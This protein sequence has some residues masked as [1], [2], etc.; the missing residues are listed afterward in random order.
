[1]CHCRPKHLQ[2]TL[3]FAGLMALLACATPGFAQ[4]YSAEAVGSDSGVATYEMENFSGS[5]ALNGTYFNIYHQSNSGVG[6]TN[7]FTQFGAFAPYWLSPDSFIAPNARMILTDNAAAGF[8][9]GLVGRWYNP[10][11]DRILGAY[12]YYDYDQS[13]Y[14]H[15]YDQLTFGVE[16]LGRI[17]DAR[18]NAYVP[19]NNQTNFDK[20]LALS[21]NMV[22]FGNRLGFVGTQLSERAMAGGDAELGFPLAP[23]M[24]WLRGYAGG[25]VYSK[26]SDTLVGGVRGRVEGWITQN[27]SLQMMVTSDSVFGTNVNF[28][29]DYRFPGY[30]PLRFFPNWTVRERM[31]N[32]V[33]RNWR[34]AVEE[35]G[36]NVNIAANNPRDNQP[37]FVVWVDPDNANPGSGSGTY[38]DPYGRLP[39]NVPNETDMVMVTRGD[40]TALTPSL[41]SINLPDYARLLGE[42]HAHVVDAWANFGPY[43]M[44]VN[45]ALLPDD[46]FRNTGLY[47]FLSNPA[48]NIVNVGN[49]NEVAALVLM[50]ATGA[51]IAGQHPNGFNFHNL[52]ISGNLG[53]GIILAD[54]QGTGN[55]SADGQIINGG[56]IY[57][58]NRNL[59]PG[60][61]NPL[62]LGNNGPVGGINI[63]TGPAGAGP[64]ELFISN[65]SMN[66]APG[67]QG[68]GIRVA[69]NDADLALVMEDVSTSGGNVVAGISIEQGLGRIDALLGNEDSLLPSIVSSNNLGAGIRLLTGFDNPMN[70][71]GT[72]I[73]ANLNVGDNLQIAALGTADFTGNFNNSRFNHSVLGSGIAL[74][75]ASGNKT[76]GLE[77]V[78]AIGNAARGVHLH[79]LGGNLTLAALDLNA[80]LNVGTNLNIDLLNTTFNGV[81]TSNPVLPLSHFDNSIT[82]AGI[83]L[84]AVNSTSYL[85]LSGL[86]ANVNPLG[87]VNLTAIGGS[88][89]FV[90]SDLTASGNIATNLSINLTGANFEGLITSD[91]ANA[92][93][94]T[95]DNS[96]LG[97]GIALTAIGG[98]ATLQMRDVR[99]NSNTVDGLVI[100]ALAG[101]QIG[102]SANAVWDGVIVQDSQF[103]GN[104]GMG[105]NQTAAGGSY[106]EVFVD[107]T[108]VSGNGFHGSRFQVLGGSRFVAL[109]DEVT[110]DANGQNPLALELP[111]IGGR[112]RGML[113]IVDGVGSVA[114]VAVQNSS[115]FGSTDDGVY[116]TTNNGAVANLRLTS[117]DIINS[118]VL[119]PGASGVEVNALAGLG[120]PS[121]INLTMDGT[122]TL[123][124]NAPVGPAFFGLSVNA[125]GPGT[126][127]NVNADGTS[128]DNTVSHAVQ[129]LASLGATVNFEFAN[130][131]AT[132]GGGDGLNA[133]TTAGS[134]FN[135]C[136]EDVHFDDFAGVG[137]RIVTT[138]PLAVTNMHVEDSSA[139][140]NAQGGLFAQA[141]L[142]GEL[143][144]RSVGSSFDNNG[145]VGP[146]PVDGVY[147]NAAGAGSIARLLFNTSSADG[148][149]RNGFNFESQF[150]AYMTARIDSISA[151]DN[152]NYGVRLDVLGLPNDNTFGILIPEG[153]NTV[154]G[155]GTGAYQINYNG[156]SVAQVALTGSFVG[157]PTNGV[158]V[159]IANVTDA[160]VS[161]IG[162]GNDNINNNAGDGININISNA[163]QAGVFITG[164]RAISNNQ[165]DGIHIDLDNIATAAAVQITGPTSVFVNDDNGVAIELTDVVLG[166]VTSPAGLNPLSVLT[167][168]DNRIFN[169]CLPQPVDVNFNFAAITPT[170]N[171]ILVD[172]LH[173]RQ[174]PQGGAGQ[175]GIFI[176]GNHVTGSGQ[177]ILT[178]NRIDQTDNGINASFGAVGGASSFGGIGIG[179]TVINSS[180][181]TGINIELDASGAPIV[182]G[183][184]NVNTTNG[185]GVNIALN[186]VIG[187]NDIVV[188]NTNVA[189]S[190][191]RG[192]S[193]EGNGAIGDV[194]LLDV[195]ARNSTAG[196][197]L[198]IVLTNSNVGAVTVDGLG[199]SQVLNSSNNGIL[200]DL[201]D[202]A[203]SGDVLLTR[204][205]VNLS[206]ANGIRLNLDGVTGAPDVSV[207]NSTINNSTLL[208]INYTSVGATLGTVTF[209]PL[210]I[211]N[212]GSTGLSVNLTNAQLDALIM[213][214]ITVTNS[215]NDGIN[216]LLNGT[217]GTPDIT[218]TN[219]TTTNSGNRGVRVVGL[220]SGTNPL[221]LGDVT[222]TNVTA[223]NSGLGEGVVVDFA[224]DAV[225]N[226]TVGAIRLTDVSSFTSGL[227]GI[228]VGLNTMSVGSPILVDGNG[229]AQ[230]NDAGG[231]GIEVRLANVTGAPDV[232]VIDYLSVDGNG[233]RGIAVLSNGSA[234]GDVTVSD[235]IVTNTLGA[236][237]VFID[238]TN[239]AVA[240]MTADGNNISDSAGTGLDVILNGVTGAPDVNVTNS[241]V[242]NSGNR[243]ISIVGTSATLGDVNLSDNTV[244]DSLGGQGELIDLTNSVVASVTADTNTITDSAGRGLDVILNGVT[245][246]P[247]I[248]ITNATVTNSGG[249]GVSVSG[250]GSGANPMALGDV[251]LT[252]VSS[253]TT[254]AG[255]GVAVVF[256]ANA[257]ANGTVGAIALNNV[258]GNDSASRG[259]LVDLNTITLTGLNPSVT[260]DG[261]GTASADDN[262]SDG[263]L[264]T[265]NT[266][267]GTPDVTIS[268]YA[269]VDNN[270]NRGIVL[271]TNPGTTP[272]DAVTVSGNTVSNSLGGQGVLIN[273]TNNLI[274][275]VTAE[276]NTISDSDGRGFDLVLNGVTGAPDITLSDITVT[277]SGGR[278]VSVAGTGSA[279]NPLS[280][281]DVTL[282]N[283]SSDTTTAGEGVAVVFS[284]DA[285]ANGLVGNIVLNNVSGNASDTTGVLVDLD[286][287]TLNGLNPAV[288][289]NGQ[290]TATADDNGADGVLVR[291]DTVT[292][293]PD[294][295]I[296]NYDSVDN[297]VDNGIVLLVPGTNVGDVEVSGNTV[298][299]VGNGN[300][301]TGILVD[302]TNRTVGSVTMDGNTIT[303]SGDRGL[304]LILNGVTGAPDITLSDI[305]VTNSGGRGVSVAG[306]GSLAN[307]LS[308]GDITLTNVSSD[309]TATEEGVAVVFSAN[310]AANGLIG[311]IALNNVS[312]NLSDSNGVLVS[313]NT[314]TLT[315]ANPSILLDGQDTA[316][317]NN[318]GAAGVRVAISNVLGAAPDVSINNYDTIDENDGAGI[319]LTVL[320]RSLDNIN[321]NGNGIHGN[322]GHGINLNLNGAPADELHVNNNDIS[323]LPP[324]PLLGF[325]VTFNAEHV[326]HFNQSQNGILITN[327]HYDFSPI[328]YSL[329]TTRGAGEVFELIFGATEAGLTTVNG[330]PVDLGAVA[331]PGIVNDGDTTLDMA[332][333]DFTNTDPDLHVDFVVGDAAAA[334]IQTGADLA[335][336]TAEITFSNGETISGV[337]G[338]TNTQTFTRASSPGDGNQGDGVHIE[339]V[340]SSIGLI[341][342]DGNTISGN[343][344]NGINFATVTNSN[345]GDGTADSFTV[346]NNTIDDNGGDGFRLVNP[347]TAGGII[348]LTFTD[349]DSI[350]GNGGNGVNLETSTEQITLT[351]TGN[352]IGTETNGNTGMGVRAV[353]S[354]TLPTAGSLTA[355]IGDSAAA[356]NTFTGNGDA[357]FGLIMTGDATGSLVVE[358][359][360]FNGS[361]N[362]SDATFAGVGLGIS[363]SGNAANI[364]N[365]IVIGDATV[366]A[367]QVNFNN[368]ASDGLLLATNSNATANVVTVQN[369]TANEN[370]GSGLNFIRQGNSRI[371][372]V[373][374]DG[375]TINGNTQHGINI[376]AADRDTPPTDT[377][378]LSDNTITNN[379]GSGIRLNLIADGDLNVTIS[380]STISNN[381]TNGIQT[382]TNAGVTDTPTIVLNIDDNTISTNTGSGI[383]IATPHVATITENTITNNTVDGINIIAPTLVDPSFPPT[384]SVD[385]IADNI[386]TLNGDDGIDISSALIVADITGNT[387]SN[388]LDD[389]LAFT[390]AGGTQ[391]ILVD[392]ND[393]HD[394][395]GDGI[396]ISVSNGAGP[397]PLFL[398]N[399]YEITGNDIQ[400]SGR[401]GINVVNGGGTNALAGSDPTDTIVTIAENTVALSQ[402]E[403]IYVIN[404]A[405]NTQGNA[406]NINNLA[407]AALLADGSV[408]ARP[409]LDLTI[410]D[411]IVD[412]NGQSQNG[413]NFAGAS[414]L[415]LRVGTSDASNSFTDPGGFASDLRGGVIATVTD[416]TFSGQFAADVTFAP[417]ISTAPPA[418]TSGTWTDQNTEPR[419]ASDD[420]FSITSYV[421]DPLARLDLVFT[422][423][424]GDGLLATNGQA[425][426]AFYNNNEPEFKSRGITGVS[427][428]TIDDGA[429]SFPAAPDDNGPFTTGTRA[430]NATRQA[431]RGGLAPT[432]AAGSTYLYPGMGA[433]TFRVDGGP[434]FA[435]PGGGGG[436]IFNPFLGT[437]FSDTQPIG[438]AFGELDF[439]WGSF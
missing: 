200:V 119:T 287:I 211:S 8:N 353:I 276:D 309:S 338:A 121:T 420:V 77:G 54:A 259:I 219:S 327:I 319:D 35:F 141:L 425:A 365:S 36:E 137:M 74:E 408:F 174:S 386:I 187:N 163:D 293:T 151:S 277:N 136:L 53:G 333:T 405:S 245:G 285:A 154:T 377:Y 204:N 216:V 330:N 79:S 49:H 55:I 120:G 249:R 343:L 281:G 18:A 385:V 38:E 360:S 307:P 291:L 68:F 323:A 134:V 279:A 437:D 170:S 422:G 284:A 346:S 380:G 189:D 348:D 308:L 280:L 172:G 275:S 164:Y 135:A 354:G 368:N 412:S 130:T 46:R 104:G 127:V 102:N 83:N 272:L 295:T 243:G 56:Q 306:I 37:Y 357:G 148:N 373:T 235:N 233:G 190:A 215:G 19:I 384:F 317:A 217:H 258:S 85:G 129:S 182:I 143:N 297:N 17:W 162:N 179:N 173:I 305:T 214:A 212:S 132:G 106:L 400:R 33:Q 152:G 314:V 199:T 185:N 399:E 322:N 220:G 229:T 274:G 196:D 364:V 396:Q 242:A 237:G 334:S 325:Q 197:G 358:N 424:T 20:P 205:N 268:N 209:D 423:N 431:S 265:L 95:F 158:E 255:E 326:S 94:S 15:T 300:G 62:G 299:T 349:N 290:G 96:A 226:G 128:F 230:S 177:V 228:R 12:G 282:T 11:W 416:N 1:M 97:S 393:I 88:L 80:S 337:F 435:N 29:G 9:A 23:G 359:S 118:G 234:V 115:I 107:P 372:N 248:N 286:T 155:N 403:G 278:G 267:L 76:L 324:L 352:T 25:Y 116:L 391:N 39:G 289:L 13:A 432:I 6:Y 52:E 26:H 270:A 355:T 253:E 41:G 58:I 302:L 14:K 10:N 65:V 362:G 244:S 257:L 329:A 266:I 43:S 340:N 30:Q 344:N 61:L 99:A 126:V 252:D 175:D 59:V 341:E 89:D 426:T 294:V 339:Q 296:S 22:F 313:L 147:V 375:G 410:D 202:S 91:P 90:A 240:S 433:S 361:I 195:A 397:V 153:T 213:D 350:S 232:S 356:A 31:L 394:N 122:T 387:I 176:D 105:I 221:Q 288:T 57:N 392:D 60:W 366:G 48:G 369:F 42:G 402:L 428:D 378:V 310:A 342:F 117:V 165:G 246:T 114:D 332:M 439:V 28:I 404:T 208:G 81:V 381:L 50:N 316:T 436:N 86:T 168:T 133:L 92:I 207:T 374:V 414:G 159:N 434:A 261:Q 335:G 5:A 157:L 407:S 388:N 415:V 24:P 193:I 427:S 34:I 113:G 318:N 247:D 82:G 203:L 398:T 110:L 2:V 438:G 140:L 347:D 75:M 303:D 231:D 271:L 383:L 312:G 167:L 87:G 32:P 73:A 406:A 206:G 304:D 409:L 181:S 150:G 93:Y 149:T 78:T 411:N 124:N 419:D 390:N 218:I 100:N 430:R 180:S 156:G 331:Q 63:Q 379:S 222:L 138:G 238:L 64:L 161:I 139:N 254:T 311:N 395:A 401:R 123:S 146:P 27:L 239:S 144:L 367:P 194:S 251:T 241:V 66:S 166:T 111:P 7:G 345:V 198:A 298:G 69:T 429:P 16:T 47:P 320:N 45:D 72:S 269:S 256:S 178:N 21:Q 315:D 4:I 40:S 301:G 328:G 192:V 71:F 273:L 382:T 321:I 191:G 223:N 417:F 224:A 131:T 225:A 283:V 3:R 160:F 263:I 421:S 264:V 236:Q 51:A 171:G 44:S 169:D 108:D 186:N 201:T 413:G 351:M 84:V 210:I 227:D 184:T 363:L 371:N 67:G 101:A 250:I 145:V 98:T 103:S 125:A 142:G 418:T 389:G 376:T 370:G 188:F 70:V 262:G 109:Y 260:V 183:N 292:G 112:G 336:V